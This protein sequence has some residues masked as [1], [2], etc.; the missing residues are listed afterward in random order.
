MYNNFH[1]FCFIQIINNGTN[2]ITI[3]SIANIEQNN[4]Y[5]CTEFYNINERIKIGIKINQGGK[6]ENSDEI[7]IV[8]DEKALNMN[9]LQY[10]SDEI[11]D[12]LIINNKYQSLIEK[13]N[14]E[15]INKTLKLKRSYMR[16][17]LGL[18]KRFSIG[19][20][21]WSYLNLYNVFFCSCK[22]LTCFDIQINKKCKYYLIR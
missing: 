12:F 10:I 5:K 14:D 11:F 9:K 4:Y 1:L 8:I 22:G 2:N 19:K 3:N 6:N 13:V 18:L 21:K 15:N 16:Y 17:P 20:E 7:K